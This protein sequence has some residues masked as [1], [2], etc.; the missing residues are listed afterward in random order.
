MFHKLLICCLGMMLFCSASYAVVIKDLYRADVAVKSESVAER[1]LAIQQALAEVLVKVSGHRDVMVDEQANSLVQQFRY[2]EQ[3]QDAEKQLFIQVDFDS[4][5]VVNLLHQNKQTVWGAVRPNIVIWLVISDGKEQRFMSNE[6]AGE[7]SK[8]IKKIAQQRGLAV[9]MPVLDLQ[10]L[11]TVS[12]EDVWFGNMLVL[13]Q[14]SQRYKADV[15]VLGRFHKNGSGQ[16]QAMWTLLS[17]DDRI[18]KNFADNKIEDVVEQGM[19]YV[20]DSLATEYAV[21]DNETKHNTI[22]LR[23]ANISS[24]EQYNDVLEDLRGL[25]PVEDIEVLSVEATA[26]VYKLMVVNGKRALL[27][28]LTLYQDLVPLEQTDK[29]LQ[30]RLQNS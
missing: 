7:L 14:A 2:Y 18:S 27:Q 25:A 1:K 24:A 13:T 26:V 6:F 20:A 21:A 8:Q 15:T 28:A 30:Y 5:G 22:L 12:A 17:N 19:Q 3:E 4:D 11:T 9:T 29:M 23:V 10:D 16:W